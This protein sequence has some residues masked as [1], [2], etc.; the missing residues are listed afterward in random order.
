M[1]KVP[2]AV[3]LKTDKGEEEGDLQEEKERLDK[4]KKRKYTNDDLSQQLNVNSQLKR[5]RLLEKKEE[6][7]SFLNFLTSKKNAKE[8][9]VDLST[10]EQPHVENGPDNK[11]TDVKK[12][13]NAHLEDDTTLSSQAKIGE[14]TKAILEVP[15]DDFLPKKVLIEPQQD[16]ESLMEIESKSLVAKSAPNSLSKKFS[17]QK[18]SLGPDTITNFEVGFKQPTPIQMEWWNHI[19]V[20]AEE[21]AKE[22]EIGDTVFN[23]Y[24]KPLP[25]GPVKRKSTPGKTKS[26]PGKTKS[27]PGKTKS[28]PSES[29]EETSPKKKRGGRPKKT[30]PKES[31]LSVQALTKSIPK[32]STQL[33]TSKSTPTLKSIPRYKSTT[34]PALQLASVESDSGLVTSTL[35]VVTPKSTPKNK[36]TKFCVKYLEQ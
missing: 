33:S 30:T 31:P 29:E 6:R 15:L 36:K 4:N 12:M 11:K 18:V 14:Q 20:E 8:E 2:V 21:E 17:K 26:T 32:Q 27:T 34:M 23:T 9:K 16:R 24:V 10:S 7:P 25:I 35:N 5:R 28:V 19:A 22:Q 3:N 1:Q 13:H